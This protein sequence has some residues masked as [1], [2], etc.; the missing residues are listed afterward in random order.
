MQSPS[1]TVLG[2]IPGIPFDL[3]PVTGAIYLADDDAPIVRQDGAPVWSLLNR[4]IDRRRLRT[5][6]VDVEVANPELFVVPLHK[7][8]IALPD[9]RVLYG[10]EDGA[11]ELID[12][13]CDYDPLTTVRL[14]QSDTLHADHV[15]VRGARRTSTGTFFVQ[16]D[17][18]EAAWTSTQETA[19]E[20]GA[21]GVTGYSGWDKLKQVTRNQEVRAHADLAPV[22]CWFRIPDD[23]DQECGSS[24]VDVVCFPDDDNTSEKHNQYV[25]EVTIEP[26]LALWENID[27]S[28]SSEITAGSR[29]QPRD[30]VRRRPL[31]VFKRPDDNRH[32]IGPTMA[33]A[34]E[35][36]CDPGD[37]G[38]SSRFNCVVVVQPSSRVVEVHVQGE[39]QHAIA[40]TDFSALSVDRDVGQYDYKSLK[41]FVTL[42]LV[43]NRYCE[44]RWPE[45][46]DSDS[47]TIDAQR[48]HV[49]SS[50]RE[51][52]KDWLAQDT[53]LDVADDGTKI[54][55]TAGGYVQDDSTT[56]Q[57]YA[58]LIY[59][60]YTTTRYALTL[61]TYNLAA[62]IDLEVGRMI[63]TLGSGGHAAAI[64][65]VIWVL[66]TSGCKCSKCFRRGSVSWTRWR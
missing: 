57:A 17:R 7:S 64:N 42:T 55:A 58:R 41:M 33:Q 66:A 21:S 62:A 8:Q 45:E 10:A 36:E 30:Y 65:S 44:G 49:I 25:H 38:T 24:A 18:F 34:A 39:Q 63:E 15:I 52:R 1:E 9:D 40:Y 37:T 47:G 19:Y 60:W 26:E 28:A 56:L 23:W 22:Y 31:L 12:L 27:Y 20:A 32:V 46:G 53:V 54:T 16:D 11:D 43:D 5:F 13:D 6:Y 51:Y 50:E 3:D 48:G 4:L 61:S 59:E 14:R 2:Y 35:G 29:S